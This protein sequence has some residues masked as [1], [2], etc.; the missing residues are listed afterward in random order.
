MTMSEFNPE[1]SYYSFKLPALADMI[2]R[3]KGVITLNEYIY[4]SGSVKK[5]LTHVD[6][7][8]FTLNKALIEK[9][10]MAHFKYKQLCP[11][12][13]IP[14][15]IDYLNQLPD[16]VEVIFDSQENLRRAIGEIKGIGAVMNY[17]EVDICKISQKG[18]VYRLKEKKE[19]CKKPKW[20][21]YNRVF[22]SEYHNIILAIYNRVNVRL[23]DLDMATKWE[24]EL[25]SVTHDACFMPDGTVRIATKGFFWSFDQFGRDLESDEKDYNLRDQESVKQLLGGR[26]FLSPQTIAMAYYPNLALYDHGLNEI[27]LYPPNGPVEGLSGV[28]SFRGMGNIEASFSEN[29]KVSIS[30]EDDKLGAIPTGHLGSIQCASINSN[31]SIAVGTNCGEICVYDMSGK[32]CYFV[33]YLGSTNRFLYSHKRFWDSRNMHGSAR[34]G[35][36]SLADNG[37]LAAEVD[38]S[39]VLFSLTENVLWKVNFPKVS[40]HNVFITSDGEYCG[41]TFSDTCLVFF[42]D[43][44][45]VEQFN[46]D[47]PINDVAIDKEQKSLCLFDDKFIS[48]YTNR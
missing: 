12:I 34:V 24:R 23:M 15:T 16:K 1:S 7:N 38:G 11:K 10:I 42:K 43:G 25:D 32:V 5:V 26:T 21:R 33:G 8:I 36:V 22:L 9:N 4:Y 46:C 29:G 40:I 37:Y 2:Y 28:L 47:A 41:C 35:S 18:T 14:K 44:T 19:M 6:K 45:L 3:E 13:D 31:N 17:K 48:Y 27:W 20:I 30:N 39:L